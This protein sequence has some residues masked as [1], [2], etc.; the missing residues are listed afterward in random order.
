MGRAFDFQDLFILDMANNHQ[1]SVE[2]GLGIIRSVADVVGKHGVR[3]A[4]K[5]QFRQLDSFIHPSH[6][7]G[8]ELKYIQRFQSTRLEREQYQL[9]LDEV[10]ARGLLAACTP[11]DEESVEIAVEMG[12]DVL[13]IASCSARDWPLLEAISEG[14]RPVVC[15]TGGLAIEDIDN[16]VSFFQHRGVEFALMHCVSLYPTPDANMN[17]G[18]IRALR[19]RYAGVPIGWSTHESPDDTVPVQI[20]VAQGATLFER[21]VGVETA[22][23]QLNAYSSNPTQ[24]DAWLAA[25]GRARVLC[26]PQERPPAT[27]AETEALDGLRRGIYLRQPVKKGIPIEREHVYFAMPYVDG[28][29]ESGHWSEG[30]V[31][32]DDLPAHAPL[33]QAQAEIPGDREARVIKQSIH[34]VKALLNQARIRLG[35][36]FQ[37]EY[38]HHYGIPRFRETGAVIVECINREYCKKLLVQLPG[39]HHPSHFHKRKEETFQVLH[40]VLQVEIGGYHRELHPGE[41]LLVQPGVWHEFWTDTGAIVE[42]VS[43]THFNDDSFYADKRINKLPRSARK[44]V[45]DNWGRFQI[46]GNGA[47]TDA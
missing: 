15:S 39:Q 33:P 45:V 42:E 5:F 17:L 35:S 24:L 12:F 41:T 34:E 4:L 25:Y 36:D 32:S 21:H 22:D 3:A 28:Q 29:V 40:G 31:A 8:S 44:T 9:L 20:A 14:G 23:I 2:H 26:G 10:S 1:G 46:D 43:T 18:Q 19:E 37:V 13:K 38:S 30:I 6:Q 7:N 11:F 16:L 47:G 27:A